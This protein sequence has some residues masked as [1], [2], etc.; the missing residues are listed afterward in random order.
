M[1]CLCIY[2]LSLGLAFRCGE[3]TQRKGWRQRSSGTT[4]FHVILL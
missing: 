1:I 4:K 3:D 2:C